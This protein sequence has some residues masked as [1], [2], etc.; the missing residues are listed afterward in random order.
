MG[1]KRARKGV[2]VNAN[3]LKAERGAGPSAGSC[4]WGLRRGAAFVHSGAV[5][6]LQSTLSGK[7]PHGKSICGA[8]AAVLPCGASK[9]CWCAPGPLG[10]TGC[11]MHRAGNSGTG[12]VAVSTAAQPVDS[13]GTGAGGGAEGGLGS[14]ARGGGGGGGGGSPPAAGA[15]PPAVLAGTGAGAGGG[16]AGAPPVTPVGLTFSTGGGCSLCAASAKERK[17]QSRARKKTQKTTTSA[18]E[19]KCRQTMG[20]EAKPVLVTTRHARISFADA[21]P[22]LW[23][24]LWFYY[25]ARF[26]GGVPAGAN[27]DKWRRIFGKLA[28][29]LHV[30]SSVGRKDTPADRVERLYG[31]MHTKRDELLNTPRYR[32]DSTSL[33]INW[34]VVCG[35]PF[36]S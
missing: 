21:P 33:N 16:G 3:Q 34:P 25:W 18:V 6:S 28:S 4:Y 14:G 32:M 24:S 27:R 30:A 22:L 7:L 15:P 19:A 2:Y 23:K 13:A 31:Y 29:K 11:S 5:V 35:R 26:S 8:C 1:K 9:G 12:I 20:F 36:W 10:S 17:R